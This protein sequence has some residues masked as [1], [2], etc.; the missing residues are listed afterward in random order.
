MAYFHQHARYRKRKNFVAKLKADDRM[1]TDQD[2]KKEVV[3]DFYNKLLGTAAQRDFTL[4]LPAFHRQAIDL[5]G[6]DQVFTE[7]EVWA[8]IKS[9]PS[10]KAPGLDGYTGR[11]YRS[12]WQVIKVD[13]MAA[14]SRLMQGDI[15]RLHLLN[16]AYITLIPKDPNAVEIKDFRPISLIH[17]FAKIVTK[18][19]ANRLA[20][21]LPQLVSPS[22]SAFV[23]GRCIRENFI[24]VQQ[25]A[26][27]MHRQKAPGVLL[28]LDISKAFDSVSRSFLSEVL[29]HLGFGQFWCNTLSKLLWSS[30]TRVLVNGEPGGI[31][32]HQRGLR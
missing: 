6:L 26:K 23:K 1:I 10:D 14:V 7:E 3:W 27:A 30:S 31:I 12:A 13:F 15:A 5:S 18:V 21:F 22:Q 32:Y 9:L 19:M 17:N 8:T 2:E 25:T 28:K 16:S 4:N 24:L 11:F 29:R 20:K